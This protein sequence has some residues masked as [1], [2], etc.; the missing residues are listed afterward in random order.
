MMKNRF[1]RFLLLVGCFMSIRAGAQK[2]AIYQAP[3]TIYRTG[4]ELVQ[5]EKYVAAQRSFEQVIELISENGNEYKAMSFFYRAYCAAF[6]MNRN[7]EQLF[8][9][10]FVKYPQHV[11]T[12]LARFSLARYYFQTKAFKKCLAQLALVDYADLK[13]DQK[14]EYNYRIGYCYFVD[15]NYV[16]SKKY[17]LQVKDLDSKFKAPATYYYSHIA[18]VDK[19]Y[20][21]ARLGF[22]SLK[23][24][25]YFNPIV[26]FYIIQIY[27]LQEKYDK[28]LEIG[29]GLL[30]K[31]SEK[32]KADIVR[33]I[34]E[35]Y[36]NTN[37]FKESIPYFE[38][39]IERIKV[40]AK[41]GDFYQ[42]GYASYRCG[43]YENAVKSFAQVTNE[44]DSLGQISFYYI[45]DCYL[46]QNKKNFAS[47]SF[48]EASKLDF[49]LNI[50][51][52]ALYNYAKL[53]YELSSNPFQT[54]I[55]SFEVF[56][57]TYPNS[58]HIDEVNSYLVAIYETTKNYKQALIS[59]DKINKK[60]PKLMAAY[61]RMA[62]FRAVELFN[63]VNYNEAIFLFR[64]A[65]NLQ[66][67]KT[68]TAESMYWMGEAYYRK[69]NYDSSMAMMNRFLTSPGAFETPEFN[70]AQYTIGYSYFKQHKYSNALTAF[71]KF[72]DNSE[73]AENKMIVS[74]ALN[75]TAD[76]YFVQ[77]NFS[78]AVVS[79]DKVIDLK[80]LDVDYAMYQKALSLGAISRAEDKIA[81]LNLLISTY[82]KSSYIDDSYF[83]LA[84]TYNSKGN[85][86][87]AIDSYNKLIN[88]FP[89]SQYVKMAMSEVGLVYNNIDKP[90]DALAVLKKVVLDYPGT[91]EASAAFSNIKNIYVENNNVEGFFA[92]VKNNQSVGSVSE[93]EQDS[94]MF[95][96][97][98]NL[99]LSDDCDKS[100][101]GFGDYMA[102]FPEGYFVSQATFYAAECDMKN[103][104]TADALKGYEFIV[105]KFQGSSF[106]EKSLLTAGGIEYANNNF[107][108]ALKYYERLMLI[109]NEKNNITIAKV[110]AMRIYFNQK[111]YV[112]AMLAA[113]EL[114]KIEKLSIPQMEEGS[115]IIIRS[116][117]A[118]DSLMI[119]EN[120]CSTLL[121]SKSE[122][123]AEAKYTLAYIEFRKG[124]F[125][126][127]EK[128]VFDLLSVGS[129]YEYWL[130]KS[131]ILLGDIY[132]E[133]GNIFQA[134][135]TYKSIVDN[136]DGADLKKIAEDKYNAIVEIENAQNKP[137][138]TPLDET[139]D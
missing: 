81:T 102:K 5:K 132:V 25:E 137:K 79:Y 31:S 76:C 42:L 16:E 71:R 129:S 124:N 117:V 48:Y 120:E 115:L 68:F 84:G 93:T 125:D 26:P 72:N 7:T 111:N 96:A 108:N 135:H 98:Y 121:K 22:E 101:K 56:V 62:Y 110:G 39:Y 94:I 134:K 113:K 103:G 61:Q 12:P 77:K 138:T 46:K 87:A 114:K 35:A 37:L 131:Y 58:K 88:E 106:E 92:W 44:K 74:D 109:A 128:K 80:M 34:G 21:T 38:Q 10:Y 53:Q 112:Q 28:I 126:A 13:E 63:D 57:N 89:N 4:V 8:N 45:A 70:L 51:E 86:A 23:D 104:K 40:Q 52:D 19:N 47:T 100:R 107:D 99:Y 64:K 136:Y 2:T 91:E 123:G 41:R 65:M 78:E 90:D 30:E 14:V 133:K 36:Y 82:P 116:A 29:P 50:K 1:F 83:E 49:L 85:F 33:M 55:A 9:D 97:A 73:K 66:F 95:K 67:N 20:E 6:L 69:E 54:A 18:Y 118:I 105:S 11:S 27:Y 75:R 127:S 122:A 17:L 130:A 119:A 139:N 15:S 24:D 32:R 59:L 43:M 3:E 60:S